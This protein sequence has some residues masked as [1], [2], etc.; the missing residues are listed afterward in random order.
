MDLP[1][2]LL[3][4]GKDKSIVRHHPWIFSG[5]IKAQEGV[6]DEGAFVQVVA[7]KGRHLGYGHYQTGSI[8][9]RVLLFAEEELTEDLYH[10]RIK[11]A[12][13]L[14]QSLGL[15][16]SEETNIFRLIHAEGDFLPG[17]IIDHYAGHLVIQCHSI[18]MYLDVEKIKDA[19]LAVMGDK[20]KSIYLK[21]TG[22]L[23]KT[24]EGY[25]GDRFLHGEVET[26][27]IALEYGNKFA[28]NWIT[29]QK[30]GFFIASQGS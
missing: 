14:R 3:K 7:N 4:P 30:T 29:G 17:L 11:A 9:V 8:M 13:A 6:I 28:I 22:T 10:D 26:P 15:A 23:P 27:Q 2:L 24:Y 18:G 21:C 20:V 16:D 12:Y 5:A 25:T 19:L 1:K